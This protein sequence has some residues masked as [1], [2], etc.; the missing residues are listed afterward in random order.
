MPNCGSHVF[1]AARSGGRLGSIQLAKIDSDK[2]FRSWLKGKPAKLAVALASRIALRVLPLVPGGWH[3][4]IAPKKSADRLTVVVFRCI[5]IARSVANY[6][7]REAGARAASAA[8]DAVAYTAATTDV[9]ARAAR[10]AAYAA[11][12]AAA[13]AYTAT[14]DAAAR[15]A[16]AAATVYSA[17]DADCAWWDRGEHEVNTLLA[18]PLWEKGMPVWF[19]SAWGAFAEQPRAGSTDWSNWITWFDRRIA[20][21]ASEWGLPPQQDAEMARRLIAADNAWWQRGEA[22]PAFINQQI[23]AWLAEL[24]PEAKLTPPET[25]LT[26]DKI[27]EFAQQIVSPQP[28]VAASGKLAMVPNPGYDTAASPQDLLDPIRQML[29]LLGPLLRSIRE[30]TPPI[31]RRNLETY[32]EDLKAHQQ[33]AC[34]GALDRLMRNAE[35]SFRAGDPREFDPGEADQLEDVFSQHGKIMTALNHADERLRELQGI[36]VDEAASGEDILAPVKAIETAAQ[37]LKDNGL[38]EPSFDQGMD[39]IVRMGREQASPPPPQPG[40]VPVEAISG[41]KVWVIGA[42]GIAKETLYLLGSTASLAM[43]PVASQAM[44]FLNEAI[45]ALMALLL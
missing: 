35:T 38:T 42:L 32:Y 14:A 34:W 9:A 8:A 16:G 25:E 17:I 22:E 43:L 21:D 11:T 27:A 44:Q 12:D 45:R 7:D 18:R 20:G 40:R 30:N 3:A 13:A 23:G 39:Q 31:I 10:A 6:A 29:L 19:A 24:T 33:D 26:P 1:R 4:P 28:V 41:L 5:A 15:A 37:T 2:A 36:K